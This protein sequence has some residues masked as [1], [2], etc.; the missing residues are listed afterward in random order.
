MT[1]KILPIDDLPLGDFQ[2]LV[3]SLILGEGIR[4]KPYVDTVGKVSIGIGR[5]LTDNGLSDDE[6]YFLFSNDLKEAHQ[7][8]AGFIHYAHLNPPRRAVIIEMAFNMGQYRL[9]GFKKMWEALSTGNYYM[10]A[11]EMLDS[12]WASQVGNRAK[13]LATIMERGTWR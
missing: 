3:D 12:K 9:A 2:K 10:A 1:D 7:T 5:N 11:S 8:A 4:K 13:R 6:L